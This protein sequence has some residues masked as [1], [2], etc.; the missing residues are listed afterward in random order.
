MA[1]MPANVISMSKGTFGNPVHQLPVTS[2]KHPLTHNRVLICT[3]YVRQTDDPRLENM[4]KLLIKSS[5]VAHEAM[6]RLHVKPNLRINFSPSLVACLDV[7]AEAHPATNSSYPVIVTVGTYEAQDDWIA[8]IEGIQQ[9]NYP[10]NWVPGAVNQYLWD[11]YPDELKSLFTRAV[12]ELRSTARKFADLLRWRTND[13]SWSASV[14]TLTPQMPEWSSDGGSEWYKLRLHPRF[15]ASLLSPGLALSEDLE[16]WVQ[17]S[18]LAGEWEP[19]GR[20]IWHAAFAANS[21]SDY[22]SAVILAVSAVE[23]ELKRFISQRVPMAEW[24]VMKLP[25]PPIRLIISEYLKE[26]G[27]CD[28]QYL[29]PKQLQVTLAQAVELRNIVIH[30]GQLG[31]LKSGRTPSVDEVLDASSDMLWLLDLYRG[32]RWA[33]DHLKDKTRESLGLLVDP[34]VSDK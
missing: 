18:V 28:D 19:L 30:R 31:I 9:E 32:H 27:V 7:D 1:L 20:D 13:E 4:A 8:L 33:L 12:T 3:R 17:S 10:P 24:L 11:F 34:E 16:R 29:P 25:S 21:R 15:S 23:T 26:L 6:T 14:L 2:T 22:R 5:S